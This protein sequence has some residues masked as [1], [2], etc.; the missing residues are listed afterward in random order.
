MKLVWA[1]LQPR[2]LDA[3]VDALES[4]AG[5]GGITVSDVRGFGRQRGA[6]GL[7][8]VRAPGAFHF[9]PK[10]RIEIVVR[11]DQVDAVVG[12]IVSTARTGNVGDGK[13]FVLPVDAAV[14]VRTGERDA[15]AL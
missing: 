9:L 3:V 7:G 10:V 6:T 1:I 14:R 11:D 15:A 2:K 5:I 4:Q 12:V 8:E 13:V